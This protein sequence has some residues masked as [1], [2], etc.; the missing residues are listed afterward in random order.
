MAA[1]A[2]IAA[3]SSGTAIRRSLHDR[4]RAALRLAIRLWPVALRGA[5]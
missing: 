4:R 5:N 3:F 1:L 2:T